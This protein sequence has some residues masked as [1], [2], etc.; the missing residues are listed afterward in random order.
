MQE[1][2]SE[3]LVWNPIEKG[4]VQLLPTQKLVINW[5]Y[6]LSQNSDQLMKTMAKLT[7]N[8]WRMG[9]I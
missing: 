9:K 4:P 7:R 3:K 2:C 6:L 1:D 8:D 5:S